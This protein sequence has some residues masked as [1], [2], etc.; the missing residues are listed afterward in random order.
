VVE[1]FMAAARGGDFDGLLA[2]L[3]PDVVL[4]VDASATVNGMAKVVRGARAVAGQARA[5]GD[6]AEFAR[7]ALIDGTAGIVVAPGGRL[8]L[9]QQMTV[10]DGKV[11]RIDLIADVDR[12]AALDIAI[13][14]D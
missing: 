5:Y 12:L 4:H 3:D 8:L 13:L 14:G 11:V 10:E 1:A 6:R 2:L 7:L 9:V